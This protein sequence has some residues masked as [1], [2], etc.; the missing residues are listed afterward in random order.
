MK[1]NKPPAPKAFPDYVKGNLSDFRDIL[2]YDLAE[3]GPE[4]IRLIV[5]R[6]DGTH[7]VQAIAHPTKGGYSIGWL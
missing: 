5:I 2:K 3:D 1:H 6:E 4:G 7:D